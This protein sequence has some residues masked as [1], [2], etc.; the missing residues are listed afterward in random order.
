MQHQIDMVDTVDDVKLGCYVYNERLSSDHQGFLGCRYPRTLTEASDRY[1][2]KV[3]VLISQTIQ[4][5]PVFP[6]VY[7]TNTSSIHLKT[8]VSL[9]QTT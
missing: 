9:G 3:H 7:G 4:V 8:R 1:P 6:V 5:L 2:R